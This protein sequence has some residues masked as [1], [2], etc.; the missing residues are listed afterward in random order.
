[1]KK[2]LF[3][4]PNLMHGGA[5]KVLI[6]LVNNLDKSKY[7][8]VLKTLFDVGVNKKHINSTVE[9]RYCFKRQFRGNTYFFKIFSP[10][11]LY[12][13]LIKDDFDIIISYLE[14]PTTRIIGGCDNLNTRKIAWNHS[15][16]ETIRNY[17]RPYRN[18]QEVYKIYEKFDKIICVSKEIELE[19][20]RLLKINK[21]VMTLYNT[22]ETNLIIKKASDPL[23]DIKLDSKTMNLCSVGKITKTK[24]Y[25]RLLRVHK[26]LIDE[27]YKIHTYILGIGEEQKALEKYIKEY[28][29]T[30]TFTFLGYKDNPYKYVAKCDLYVCASY[31]EGFNTAVTESLVVGTPVITTLCSGMKE[32]LGENDEYGVIVENNE[33]ALYLGIKRLISRKDRLEYYKNK[34]GERGRLFSKES[35]IKAVEKML[36]EL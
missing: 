14:G 21:E 29:L 36:D 32:M 1:M 15:T 18:E 5:E 26:Q 20:E 22:I 17:A 19:I 9:Y 10:H 27:G 35:T 12:K 23:L 6:N 16:M 30:K 7:K 8:I 33:E 31:R 28:Q 11:F 3:L 24:G 25:D 4:I 13:S 34:A 2:I